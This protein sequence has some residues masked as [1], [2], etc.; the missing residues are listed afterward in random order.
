M[1]AIA[2]A[3]RYAIYFAPPPGSA[4]AAFGASVIGYD[5]ATG[6]EVEFPTELARAFANWREV[7]AEPSRYGFHATLKAPFALADGVS[8][9]DLFD[10]VSSL[11]WRLTP[12][13]LGALGIAEIGSFLALV[14]PVGGAAQ[15]LAQSVVEELDHLRAPLSDADRARRMQALLSVRQIGYLDRWGYPYVADEFRFHM[16]LTGQLAAVERDRAHPL[17]DQ[18][19]APLKRPVSLHS[20]SIFKQPDRAQRFRLVAQV[21]LEGPAG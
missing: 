6:G 7:V 1:N 20:L 18:L 4:L 16:T 19:Y 17:L 9:S 8:E 13:E 14:P 10:S 5:V 11:A 3:A 21:R 15:S 12:V 2:P